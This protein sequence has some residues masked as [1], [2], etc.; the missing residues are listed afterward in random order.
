[1]AAP[2]MG[3]NVL[4]LPT[5]GPPS[6]FVPEPDPQFQ[7]FSVSVPIFQELSKNPKQARIIRKMKK[8]PLFKR[9]EKRT[10]QVF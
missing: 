10:R 2:V 1:M 9:S 5:L 6:K 3:I 4:G 7:L 8:P